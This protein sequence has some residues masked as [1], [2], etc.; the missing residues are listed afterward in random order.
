MMLALAAERTDRIGLGPGVLVPSLRHPMVNA[1]AT[2]AL[3]ELAPGRVVVAFGTGF[4]GRRA[5]GIP[6]PIKWS[7][8]ADYIRA[9]RGLLRGETVEWEGARMR[10]LHPPGHA[11]PRPVEVPVLIAAQGPKGQAVATELADG[12][13]TVSAVPDF[14]KE[15]S[16]VPHLCWGTVLEDGEEPSSDRVRAAAGPGTVVAL[17]GVYEYNGPVAEMPGG[18]AWL[19]EIER[20][21]EAERHLAVH[22]QHCV[23][24]SA[25]DAAAW[26]AG[27]HELVKNVTV[28]GSRDE[29]RER[30]AA[31]EEQGATEIVYQPAGPDIRRELERFMEAAST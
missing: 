28:S 25:A 13:Y 8:V 10:M 23:D 11:A 27:A 20:V 1:A 30:L 16:W 4:T 24:L 12:L 22:E 5:M 6:R 31:I 3:E 18:A 29:V 21:P 19:A 14:G 2:A 7:Y 9:Y 15:F 26:E 17:H